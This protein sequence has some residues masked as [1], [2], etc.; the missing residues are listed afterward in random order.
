[1][2]NFCITIHLIFHNKKIICFKGFKKNVAVSLPMIK[3]LINSQSKFLFEWPA[4]VPILFKQYSVLYNF[5]SKS[6]R[7]GQRS[8]AFGIHIR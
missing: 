2:F 5:Q 1:M 3:A 8:F 6:I 7:L 4:A